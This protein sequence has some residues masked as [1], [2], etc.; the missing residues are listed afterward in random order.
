MSDTQTY[1]YSL[2]PDRPVRD[3]GPSLGRTIDEAQG[4]LWDTRATAQ[5]AHV[6]RLADGWRF[7]GYVTYDGTF[8][9]IGA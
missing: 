5:R 9:R 7:M 2:G 1:G 8:A 6:Y 4:A 3:V